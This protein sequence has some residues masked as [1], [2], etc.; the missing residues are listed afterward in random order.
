MLNYLI[1][2]LVKLLVG[3]LDAELLRKFTDMV[4]DFAENYVIGTKSDIDDRIVLPLCDA[5]R[6]ILN[7]P[8]ND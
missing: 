1:G 5:L 4:L 2:Q 3:M 8:D 7:V 6:R